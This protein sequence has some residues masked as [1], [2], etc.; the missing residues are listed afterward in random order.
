[1]H[2]GSVIRHAVQVLVRLLALGTLAYAG[3]S[4]FDSTIRP[5]ALWAQTTTVP[6]VLVLLLSLAFSVAVLMGPKLWPAGHRAA[7]PLGLALAVACF[8]DAMVWMRLVGGGRV[9]TS[10]PVPIGLV[11]G[12]LVV[13]WI[14]TAR[15]APVP[16]SV[17]TQ[18]DLWNKVLEQA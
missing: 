18:R 4:L 2:V 10:F 1:M 7:R 3:A 13:L 5:T 9:A 17:R 8:A 16:A 14:H 6:P 15:R 11:T 12:V